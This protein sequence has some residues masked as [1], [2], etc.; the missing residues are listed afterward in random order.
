[1]P[2]PPLHIGAVDAGKE[3]IGFSQTRRD[4]QVVH[5]IENGNRDDRCDDVPERDVHLL[6][7]SL[8]D[9]SEDVHGKDHPEDHDTDIERPFKLCILEGLVHP[10]QQAQCRQ[11]DGSVEQVE[12]KAR[13]FREQERP[14]C[15]PHH[16]VIGDPEYGPDTEPE[17]ETVRV[18]HPQTSEGKKGWDVERRH[19]HLYR[20]PEPNHDPDHSPEDRGDDKAFYRLIIVSIITHTV[21]SLFRTT[22]V[23]YAWVNSICQ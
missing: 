23:P 2:I 11:D 6:F 10:R 20:D 14:L 16:D 13:K 5:D 17:S 8:D 9:G 19:P 22:R 18:Y 3:M 4:R 1:M 21:T 12:V 7:F 15:Q